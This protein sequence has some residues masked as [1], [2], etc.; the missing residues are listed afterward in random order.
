MY[1][2]TVFQLVKVDIN[3]KNYLIKYVFLNKIIVY[4]F[5]YGIAFVAGIFNENLEQKSCLY[6]N[7]CLHNDFGNFISFFTTICLLS[8][9]SGLR[10]ENQW[11]ISILK[12]LYY[13]DF[14]LIKG[15][16]KLTPIDFTLESNVEFCR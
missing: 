13:D 2:R 10:K 14:S 11:W 1:F 12:W 16:I 3:W 4:V 6:A 15:Y 5:A 9:N 8:F 7:L